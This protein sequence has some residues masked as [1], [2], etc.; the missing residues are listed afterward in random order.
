MNLQRST[1][2]EENAELW[3]A[4]RNGLWSTFQYGSKVLKDKDDVRFGPLMLPYQF[5]NCRL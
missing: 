1:N 4:R 2:D 5:R 3:A